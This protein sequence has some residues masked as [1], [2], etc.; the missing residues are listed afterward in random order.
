MKASVLWRPR[1]LSG[2]GNWWPRAGGQRFVLL[3]PAGGHRQ[4][5]TP[6]PLTAPGARRW[7]KPFQTGFTGNSGTSR[8]LALAME[9]CG[10]CLASTRSTESWRRRARPRFPQGSPRALCNS[11]RS[12]WAR[13]YG[14]VARPAPIGW[15]EE[16][17]PRRTSP[18]LGLG[19]LPHP[20]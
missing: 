8:P 13:C 1:L 4:R 20:Y 6:A 14:N 11:S 15:E 12:R 18:T 7:Q 3:P 19:V 9:T 5:G 16:G 2:T 17:G 10:A